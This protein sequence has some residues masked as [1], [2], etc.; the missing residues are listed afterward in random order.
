MPVLTIQGDDDVLAGKTV[1]L[2]GLDLREEVEKQTLIGH[3]KTDSELLSVEPDRS[4]I[5]RFSDRSAKIVGPDGRAFASAL[6]RVPGGLRVDIPWI[7]GMPERKGRFAYIKRAAIR[8]SGDFSAIKH[9]SL[10]GVDEV[11]CGVAAT[12]S[13]LAFAEKERPAPAPYRAPRP[14]DNGALITLGLL[15]FLTLH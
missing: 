2:I 7:W 8:I 1:Q 3:W 5:I 4:P 12:L 6:Q 11:S 14:D 13:G 10:K 15:Y 9:P